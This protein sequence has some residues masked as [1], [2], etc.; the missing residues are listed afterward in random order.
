VVENDAKVTLPT[1]EPPSSSFFFNA[2][3][4]PAHQPPSPSS[5]IKSGDPSSSSPKTQTHNK[6]DNI[7]V[8]K[9][10][11]IA[12]TTNSGDPWHNLLLPAHFINDLHETFASDFDGMSLSLSTSSI[13][14]RRRATSV[15]SSSFHSEILDLNQ[16]HGEGSPLGYGQT[17]DQRGLSP[18]LS[19]PE[20]RYYAF[21]PEFYGGV[22]EPATTATTSHCATRNDSDGAFGATQDAY[23]RDSGAAKKMKE[24]GR[25]DDSDDGRNPRQGTKTRAKDE[26]P[27]VR[28]TRRH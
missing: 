27:I 14:R 25:Q 21:Y 18:S 16:G 26:D 28:R 23:D 7:S 2:Y 9:N 15:G 12:A 11:T 6:V 10:D 19:A 24:H 1:S 22:G 3:P 17:E 20:P 5:T 4:L 13:L 8:S